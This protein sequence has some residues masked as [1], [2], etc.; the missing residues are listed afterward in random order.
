MPINLPSRMPLLQPKTL[1]STLEKST[2]WMKNEIRNDTISQQ[3]FSKENTKH[4]KQQFL[5]AHDTEILPTQHP[6]YW[7][8]TI[9][10]NNLNPRS[11]SLAC[12][13]EAGRVRWEP[14]FEPAENQCP[15]A[16]NTACR[17]TRSFD[18]TTCATV[19]RCVNGAAAVPWATSCWASWL[20]RCW[21]S[22][23]RCCPI[24]CS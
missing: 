15:A 13:S 14:Q 8:H 9:G 21:R 7:P 24:A 6:D 4:S 17:A 11:V 5:C 22:C 18:A 12:A 2:D 1:H 23:C 10:A 16:A 19:P 3:K 20:R